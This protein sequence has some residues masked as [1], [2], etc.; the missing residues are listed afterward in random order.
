MSGSPGCPF[1]QRGLVPRVLGDLLASLRSAPGLTSWRLEL[2]YLEVYNDL[3][4]D[5]LDINTSPSELTL[6]EDGAGQLQVCA[7][8]CAC[9][10]GGGIR[11]L[12]RDTRQALTPDT[13]CVSACAEQVAG[14]RRVAVSSEAEALALFFEVCVLL[15][16]AGGGGGKGTALYRRTLTPPPP[17]RA[18]CTDRARPTV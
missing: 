14:A 13:V 16:R 4:Y 1:S 8:V 2:S 17:H 3:L 7:C 10:G 9:G 5:L 6:Y 11:Q 18:A 12:L 15:G